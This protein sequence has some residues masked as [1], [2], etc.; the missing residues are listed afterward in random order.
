MINVCIITTVKE[1]YVDDDKR[2]KNKG[3]IAAN[4]QFL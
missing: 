3:I 4:H 1:E 2:I